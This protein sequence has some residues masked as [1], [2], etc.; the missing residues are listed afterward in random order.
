MAEIEFWYE[1]GSTY[2]YPAAMRIENCAA[3][4]GVTVRWQPFLLGPIFKELGWNT[5]PFNLQIDKG[6]YMWRD[7]ERTCEALGLPPF[8]R[9]D[10]FPQNSL[11][12]A[13]L[14]LTLSDDGKR[15]EFSRK[16]YESQFADGRSID[17]CKAMSAILEN[18]GLEPG[19][20]L[21]LASDSAT[22]ADLKH[23]VEKAKA[24]GIF[25]APTFV[26]TDKELF[27]GN[28]RL[29]AAIAWEVA[30]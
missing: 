30:G 12:A 15:A 25:G 19:D 7:L 27:W 21:A 10:P 24:L 23:S 6:R 1:F 11:M 9:P 8:K 20:H 5:S 2:S 29:E 13:R 28:D 14:A 3:R 17:D 26:T 16:V 18:M 4:H 22:K